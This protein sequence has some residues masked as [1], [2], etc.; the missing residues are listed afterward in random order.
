MQRNHVSDTVQHLAGKNTYFKLPYL[1]PTSEAFGLHFMLDGRVARR[2]CGW[3]ICGS[4]YVDATNNGWLAVRA[5]KILLPVALTTATMPAP[6]R[7][8]MLCARVAPMF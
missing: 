2:V 5:T 7:V 6:A 8:L 3:L 4:T 1:P